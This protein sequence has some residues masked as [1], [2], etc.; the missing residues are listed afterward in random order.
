[1]EKPVENLLINTIDNIDFINYNGIITLK[2][3]VI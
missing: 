1:V 3:R 2:E